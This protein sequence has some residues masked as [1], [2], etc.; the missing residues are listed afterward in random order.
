MRVRL[1]KVV[2]VVAVV[3]AVNEWKC[4]VSN[5]VCLTAC[6]FG[7]ENGGWNWSRANGQRLGLNGKL[8]G[9]SATPALVQG[10]CFARQAAERKERKRQ[11]DLF[12]EWSGLTDRTDG[13]EITDVQGCDSSC[14]ACR[15]RQERRMRCGSISRS[16]RSVQRSTVG[17]LSCVS[18]RSVGLVDQQTTPP[19]S[20]ISCMVEWRLIKLSKLGSE[21][22]RSSGYWL[23]GAGSIAFL[24]LS[25]ACQI[26]ELTWISGVSTG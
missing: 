2:G 24:T 6:V 3:A 9:P 7:L 12:Q 13:R 17:G 11:D 25:V 23:R 18:G 5:I 15:C 21:G 10:S 19:K 26:E 1:K 4:N 8:N 20:S 14:A 16:Y 22:K